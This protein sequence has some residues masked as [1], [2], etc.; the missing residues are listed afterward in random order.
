MLRGL[1]GW[2]GRG[3]WGGCEEENLGGFVPSK[4]CVELE[5]KAGFLKRREGFGV[6][7]VASFGWGSAEGLRGEDGDGEEFCCADCTTVRELRGA[8]ERAEGALMRSGC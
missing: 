1:R 5:G 8:I 3:K 2:E 7:S 6:G 4:K